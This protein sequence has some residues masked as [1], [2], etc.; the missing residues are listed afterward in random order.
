MVYLDLDGSL[1]QSDAVTL[2]LAGFIMFCFMMSHQESTV[3]NYLR[4]MLVHGKIA[5]LNR[6][7][8]C[9]NQAVCVF[10][11]FSDV[12]EPFLRLCFLCN[13][14]QKQD[15]S[16]TFQLF[17]HIL[18]V[19]APFKKMLLGYYRRSKVFFFIRFYLFDGL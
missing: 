13:S 16:L 11:C 12:W 17:Q 14:I 18:A 1:T 4:E 9:H 10:L 2:K 3:I 8:F 6:A 7:D 5:H 19:S 15:R